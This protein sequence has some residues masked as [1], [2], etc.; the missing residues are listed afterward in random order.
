MADIIE[1]ICQWLA[2]DIVIWWVC[3]IA[4]TLMTKD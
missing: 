4:Y 2:A 3:Q 1:N